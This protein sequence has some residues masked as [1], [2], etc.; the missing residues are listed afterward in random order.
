MGRMTPTSIFVSWKQ[1]CKQIIR[2][3]ANLALYAVVEQES[4]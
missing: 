1:F 4:R 2:E 3:Y